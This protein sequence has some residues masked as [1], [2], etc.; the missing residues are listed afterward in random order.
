MPSRTL[1]ATPFATLGSNRWW[2]LSSVV[3]SRLA[4]PWSSLMSVTAGPGFQRMNWRIF[5][6]PSTERTMRD[7]ATRADSAWDW[8]SRTVRYGCI[9]ERFGRGTAPKAGSSS[10]SSYHAKE[11]DPQARRPAQIDENPRSRERVLLFRAQSFGRIHMC[12]FPGGDRTS[13]QSYHRQ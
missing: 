6:G 4:D 3:K 5:F 9:T 12:G 13:T 10:A 7:S 11:R 1:S 8:Q 2:S